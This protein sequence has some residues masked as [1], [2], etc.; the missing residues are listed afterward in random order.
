MLRDYYVRNF[1]EL[2]EPANSLEHKGK[3]DLLVL[4]YM[5]RRLHV[6]IRQLGLVEMEGGPQLY[7]LP[8]RHQR[9]HRILLYQQQELLTSASLFFVGFVSR[10][11]K[12][13]ESLVVNDIQQADEAMLTELAGSGILSYSSLELR[14]G[15]WC[16]LVIMR[17]AS[18]KTHLKNSQVHIHAAHNLAHRY[19]E[20]IRLH[21]GI[22]REGL[23][24]TEMSVLRTKYYMFGE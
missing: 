1:D 12:N 4:R 22:M 2:Q 16:N 7:I 11:Q 9:T 18:A 14:N 17:D 20:W 3:L 10:R 5:A 19:Y 6:I 23:D 24:Y 15:D 13:V 8:E 21:N